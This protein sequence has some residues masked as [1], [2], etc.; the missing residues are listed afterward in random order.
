MNTNH[1]TWECECGHF[2]YGE[3]PPGECQKC[4][5]LESFTQM[6]D[7]PEDEEMIGDMLG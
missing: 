7:H 2:E 1:S 5:R 6:F 4:W 3:Y